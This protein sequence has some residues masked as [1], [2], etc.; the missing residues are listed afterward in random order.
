MAMGEDGYYPAHLLAARVLALLGR[1]ETAASHV[2]R[3]SRLTPL[4]SKGPLGAQQRRID[5][6]TDLSP[7]PVSDPQEN[8]SA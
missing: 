3:A 6:E 5:H 2:E 4:G 1:Y 8:P 7:N